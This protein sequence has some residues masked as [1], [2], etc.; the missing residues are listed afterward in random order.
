MDI[1]DILTPW[2]D[3]RN[4]E[5]PSL[6]KCTIQGFPVHMYPPMSYLLDAK[7]HWEQHSNIFEDCVMRNN[8]LKFNGNFL[9][10]ILQCLLAI[11]M[12]FAVLYLADIISNM[13]IIASL[14]A[15]VFIAFVRPHDT[16]SHSRCLIRWIQRYE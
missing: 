15:S 7:R 6:Q 5:T 10:D 8:N 3:E 13:L 2:E 12:I 16:S 4:T 14:G 9:Q 11:I 1:L